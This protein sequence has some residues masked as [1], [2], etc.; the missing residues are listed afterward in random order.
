M[1][2]MPK[3]DFCPQCK[4]AMSNE[5]SYYSISDHLGCYECTFQLNQKFLNSATV[6]KIT[7]DKSRWKKA[8]AR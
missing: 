2:E 5:K 3:L 1:I 6:G 7:S 8:R 4:R